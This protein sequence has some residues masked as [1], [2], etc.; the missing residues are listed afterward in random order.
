MSLKASSEYINDS[1][2]ES[3]H[4]CE[5]C[6]DCEDYQDYANSPHLANLET[7]I[8][9]IFNITESKWIER[10]EY[11]CQIDGTK[12]VQLDPAL[13]AELGHI[14]EYFNGFI[15]YDIDL[16]DINP[17]VKKIK[18]IIPH[19]NGFAHDSL[20]ELSIYKFSTIY[21]VTIHFGF[22]VQDY[23]D[24]EDEND[25][26]ITILDKLVPFKDKYFLG[27]FTSAEE[28]NNFVKKF[29]DISKDINLGKIS[30][31]DRFNILSL[32]FENI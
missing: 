6:E 18:Y 31:F 4:D 27:H 17:S 23:D 28:A 2:N 1:D 22:R 15:R 14:D 16:H 29:C 7:G 25:P 19:I 10:F 9:Y 20:P 8:E 30:A 13:R 11:Y 32:I 26:D 24:L 12:F 3:N 5:D 21:I